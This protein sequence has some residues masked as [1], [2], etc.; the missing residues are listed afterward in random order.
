MLLLI[1][2]IISQH[3][4]SLLKISSIYCACIL[5]R[6]LPANKRH[7]QLRPGLLIILKLPEQNFLARD[8][9]LLIVVNE[10]LSL[11]GLSTVATH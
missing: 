3:C 5:A 4:I 7:F 9:N 6:D 1:S 11:P 10:L 8:F 2:P